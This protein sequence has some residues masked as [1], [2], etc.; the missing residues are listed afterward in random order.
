MVRPYKTVTQ[1]PFSELKLIIRNHPSKDPIMVRPYKIAT[2]KSFNKLK[3]IINN[4]PYH[5]VTFK[6]ADAYEEFHC[7]YILSNSHCCLNSFI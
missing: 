1:K 3:L 6:F 2:Q 4:H 5:T 7:V